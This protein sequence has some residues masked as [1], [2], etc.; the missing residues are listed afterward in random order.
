S[1]LQIQTGVANAIANT[2]T[3]SLSNFSV[4]VRS[5]S[6]AS[7][8]AL[9]ANGGTL[10]LGAGI[11]EI[12]KMLLLNGV[13]QRPGTYGSSSS[14]ATFKRD[15]FFSGSGMIT[16]LV[17]EPAS[18]ALLLLGLTPLMVRKRRR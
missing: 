9:V 7:A 6:P 10:D 5:D 14:S 13:T 1:Q 15:S 2:A 16:V 12:V 8:D 11:N 17:P 3:L 18:A 4:A